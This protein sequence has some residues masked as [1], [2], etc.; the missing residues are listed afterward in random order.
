[1][2]FAVYELKKAV[3]GLKEVRVLEKLCPAVRCSACGHEFEADESAM[4]VT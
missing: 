2:L 3:M 4:C 1:M